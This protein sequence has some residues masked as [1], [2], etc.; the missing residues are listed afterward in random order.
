METTGFLWAWGLMPVITALGKMRREDC[1]KFEFS[2][3]DTVRMWGGGVAKGE[4]LPGTDEGLWESIP[5][6]GREGGKGELERKKDTT[7]SE[8]KRAFAPEPW[9]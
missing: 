6:T 5:S 1:F 4:V 9:L 8:P 7:G 3:G 2:L